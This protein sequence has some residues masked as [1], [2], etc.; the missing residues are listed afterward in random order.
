MDKI[1][2]ISGETF[3]YWSPIILAIATV[4]AIAIYAAFY[5]KKAGNPFA[6]SISILLSVMLSIPLARLVHWYHRADAYDSLK[7]AF[8][9]FS[10]GGYALIGVFVGCLLTACLLRLVRVSDNLPK[11]LDCMAIGGGT[12]IAV[13]R[14][15]SI[16]STTDRGMILPD[17]VG[18]PFAYPVINAVSGAAENRLATF[19]I[20]A[21]LTALIV[22]LLLVYMALSASKK[23]KIADG[24]VFLIFM[25]AYGASQIICD[26]TR[27]DSLY[28]R[29]NRFVSIVQI[30]GLVLLIIPIILFSVR[31]VKLDRLRG[32]YFAIWGGILALSGLAGFMEYY[33]QRRGSEAAFAYSVMGLCLVLIVILGLLLRWFGIK[34]ERILKIP[35]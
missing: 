7:A 35:E 19:M 11:M 8:T 34:K 29:S 14:L 28:L 32:R 31:T 26:S 2:F 5:I 25:M 33:V 16:F 22:V 18:F 3:I 13:G 9:D 27:Y 6:M 10:V 4:A 17:Q 12:G 20:Q 1:A 23:R 21:F 30:L 24:D 15:A